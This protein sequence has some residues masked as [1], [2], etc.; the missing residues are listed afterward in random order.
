M[1]ALEDTIA[2]VATPAGT[3]GL[4]VLRLSGAKALEIAGR[5]FRGSSRRAGAGGPFPLL[6]RGM[7]FGR[8]TDPGN[9]EVLDEGILLA[10]PGPRSYTG[11]DVAEFHV[12]GSPALLSRF[13]EVLIASGARAALP[14]EFTYRAFA[15]GRLDLV[16]AEA[17]ESLVGAQGE[18]ARRQA[19]R[20][21]TGGLS[22]HLEPLEEALKSLY[23][24]IEARLEFSEDGIPPLDLG[25]FMKEAGEVEAS[26]QR[27][28]QS[29]R[30]GKVIHDGL[31]VALVGP[32]NTGKSSLL[33]ALLG[34]ERAIVA[35]TAGTTRDVVEG[36]ILLEGAKVRLFDTAGI[37][38]AGDGVEAEGVRRSRLVLEEA[39]AV[40]WLLDASRPGESLAELRVSSLPPDRTWFLFNKKDLIGDKLAWKESGLEE[41]RCLALS[42]RTGEGLPEVLEVLRGW[43][44]GPL[45]GEDAVLTSARHQAEVRAA[46]QALQNLRVLVESRQPYELWAEEL[47]S[48]ALALGRIRGRNL[49]AGAFEDI[50]TKFCIGK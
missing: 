21:L 24:K 1:Y 29:Y 39:D 31:A 18:A 35:P 40:F 45:S 47:K 12:H 15:H 26:L 13:L 37:R 32:P 3:G 10:M 38:E 42:C 48:A 33:N 50:F 2:A 20:Q 36:E 14:G 25:K 28:S 43:V 11:E 41:K 44:R 9:G 27:L 17:V 5:I 6:A 49:P 8:F 4:G 19:L 7:H 46:V 22:S 34:R 16:Q 23:L 30:Q